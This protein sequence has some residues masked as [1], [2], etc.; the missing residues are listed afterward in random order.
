MAAPARPVPRSQE[1]RERLIGAAGAV[2]AAR[3]YRGATLRDIAERAGV[4]LAAAHYHFG[5]KRDLYREVAC[6]HFGRLEARLRAEGGAVGDDL[7]GASREQLVRLLRARIHAL[8]GTLLGGD[9]LHATL[10]LREMLDPSAVLPTL[11]RRWIDPLRVDTERILAALAPR[12][13]AAAIER[14]TRS[15]VGQVFFHRT[16]RPALLLMMGRRAYPP[17]FADEVADHVVAF[18]LGG[19]A[20]LERRPPRRARRRMRRIR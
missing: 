15:V 9:D 17:D 16:H 6:E 8:L 14:A 7:A 12:L 18:T 4:N 20:E 2:F 5:S 19:L 10:M 11:V 1:T 3:G 13:D